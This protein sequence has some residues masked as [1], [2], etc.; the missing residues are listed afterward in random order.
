MSDLKAL[1]PDPKDLVMVVHHEGD[2]AAVY[3]RGELVERGH[4]DDVSERVLE[5]LIRVE[6][7]NILVMP[8]GP[9]W[10]GVAPTLAEIEGI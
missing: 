2:G 10:S 8:E 3:Y 4:V 5:A 7:G 1:N 6:Y 9:G